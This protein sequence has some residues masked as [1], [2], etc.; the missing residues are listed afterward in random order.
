MKHE[1]SIGIGVEDIRPP[2]IEE[3]A[4]MRVVYVDHLSLDYFRSQGW[5]E[6][7]DFVSIPSPVGGWMKLLYRER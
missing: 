5:I 6:H 7:P 2:T 4:D 3:L 1:P